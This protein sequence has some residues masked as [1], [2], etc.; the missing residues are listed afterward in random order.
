MFFFP[1]PAPPPPQDPPTSPDE[2]A[3]TATNPNFYL[4]CAKPDKTCT[5]TVQ[6]GGQASFT[7]IP[8]GGTNKAIIKV[9]TA[10]QGLTVNQLP[11]AVNMNAPV[12]F[13]V[14]T[15]ALIT[16]GRYVVKLHGQN[17][18]LTDAQDA[19]IIVKTI[20]NPTARVRI[21]LNN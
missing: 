12:N 6:P 3:V 18:T 15:A 10:A 11:Q 14:T 19:T 9:N 13:T 17:N 16:D 8:R 4:E 7:V 2:P 21:R 20:T 1:N 5:A